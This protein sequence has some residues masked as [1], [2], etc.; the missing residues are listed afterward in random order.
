MLEYLNHR[1]AEFFAVERVGV[2]CVATKRHCPIET[3]VSRDHSWC[4]A[5][6]RFDRRH[7][8]RFVAAAQN[9]YVGRAVQ[10]GKIGVG[11]V[12]AE[13]HPVGEVQLGSQRFELGE[14]GLL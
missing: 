10:V 13:M 5:C 1:D 3:S 2:E 11:N 6:H 14:L 8:E 4:A 9:K 7:A 12:A